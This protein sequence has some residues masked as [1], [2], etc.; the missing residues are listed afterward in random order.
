MHKLGLALSGGGARGMVHI[1]VLQA[2]EEAGIEPG[3]LAGTSAGSIVGALW[4]KGYS[5]AEIR[6]IANKQ[7]L[8]KIAGFKIPGKGIVGHNPLRKILTKHL[9]QNDFGILK[10]PFHVAVANLNSGEAE[11]WSSGP[12]IDLVIASSSVPVV[13]EPVVIEGAT[14][15][16]GGLLMNLPALPIRPLCSTL[17][18][19]N[20]VPNVNVMPKDLSSVMAVSGRCFDLSAFNNIK[21]HLGAVDVVIEPKAI[22]K[23]SRFNFSDLQTMYQI[24]YDEAKRHIPRIQKLMSEENSTV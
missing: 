15:V 6:D 4:A 21:P 3:V 12:L 14:Y 1:G 18:C 2:L 10:I 5:A 11:V 16:D 17:V 19:V 23:Y 7:S 13:F 20:L 9:G 8:W 24:G 22:H